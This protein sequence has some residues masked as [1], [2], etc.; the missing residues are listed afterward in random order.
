MFTERRAEPSIPRTDNF[1]TIITH[2]HEKIYM[3][4]ALFFDRPVIVKRGKVRLLHR[5]QLYAVREKLCA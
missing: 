1:R 5:R 3:G 2:S 4:I